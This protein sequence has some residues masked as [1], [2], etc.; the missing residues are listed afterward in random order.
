[1]TQVAFANHHAGE[2]C[3]DWHGKAYDFAHE[4]RSERE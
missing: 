2:K 3:A 4:R 1:M